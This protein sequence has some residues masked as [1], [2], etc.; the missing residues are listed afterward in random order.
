MEIVD[1]MCCAECDSPLVMISG[2]GS[3]CLSCKFTPSMQDTYIQK[4]WFKN[5][6]K[7]CSVGG[8]NNYV[9]IEQ[10]G[11]CETHTQSTKTFRSI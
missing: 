4:D 1:V 3:Y 2:R 11:H 10:T 6:N 9:I 8:C 5:R 7:T